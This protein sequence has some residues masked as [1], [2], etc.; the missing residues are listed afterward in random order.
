MAKS[1]FQHLPLP[2]IAKGTAKISGGGKTG[3]RTKA[4][5]K[6]RQAHCETISG[7]IKGVSEATAQR[8][9]QR[10]SDAPPLPPGIPLVLEIDTGLPLDK[11]RQYFNFEIVLEDEDGYVIV[12]TEDAELT[13]LQKMVDEFV[14]EVHGSATAASIYRVDD[15]SEQT[16]RLE[17]I[18][19]NT[20]FETWSTLESQPAWIVDVGVECT[21]TQEID[22]LPKRGVRDSDQDWAK[23]QH[24]WSEQRLAAYEQWDDLKEVRE[25]EV[26]PI[27]EAYNGEILQ[28][29]DE[30]TFDTARLPDSFT[31]R[32]RLSGVGL[33]DFVLNYAYIFEVVEPDDIEL[34]QRSGDAGDG[35]DEPA[36]TVLSPSAD[37]PTVCVIDSG[38]QESHRLIQPAIDSDNSYSYLPDDSSV[39]DAVSAGGHGT[40]VAGA[41]IFGERVPTDGDF[42]AEVWVQNARVLNADCG[43]PY[44]LLPAALLEAIVERYHNGPKLTRIFNQS[45]NAR[46]PCRLKHMSSWAAAIDILSFNYDILLIQ[47]AGNVPCQTLVSSNP[48]VEEHLNAGR[49]YPDFLTERS[50][51][52][53]NPAQ[54]FQAITVGSVAYGAFENEQ[55]ESLASRLGD[56]SA[57]SRSGLGIWGV[58]KPDVVEYGGDLL[59]SNSGDT[60]TPTVGREQYPE[61]VRSTLNGGPA[62]DRDQVGTS[63]A[64]PKVTRIA[65]A[66]QQLLPDEPS[67]LYRALIIHSARWPEWVC[68]AGDTY[69]R[70]LAMRMF[71]FGIPDVDRATSSGTYRSTLISK[72][73]QT[74]CPN[75]AKVFQIPV[76]QELRQQ[77]ENF[78]IQIQV[79][80]S[81]AAQPRRTRRGRRRYLSTWLEWKT[82]NLR[83]SLSSFR[84][85]VFKDDDSSPALS[86]G[87]SIPW[88]IKDQKHYGIEGVSRS[89]GTVQ[90]DWAVVKSNELPENFC[91]AVIGHKGWSQDPETEAKFALAVSFESVTQELEIHEQLEVAVD[92]L[93]L[94]LETEV[95]V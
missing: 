1:K 9:S 46:T 65:A 27:A 7:Q 77:G 45:I 58:T 63:F 80:L 31:V 33:R 69:D 92:E 90:K 41:V 81:Y 61:L 6:N 17:R 85:R 82:S 72:G 3:D 91:V 84:H 12:A 38:I 22:K 28:I 78:D 83:E 70:L 35:G 30:S 52:I 79:T 15:D 88:V 44:G 37:A 55:W 43:M 34:P 53:S 64:A 20:I 5:K 73:I 60:G 86:T 14:E 11:L 50:F 62:C 36:T 21:G 54:S 42:Q 13:K 68:E 24:D 66:L 29:V 51:R 76:P 2:F 89:T 19:S 4:H 16:T 57:F 94:E 71:G 32:L 18:L 39:A 10:P 74:I 59:I 75:E 67:L 25:E 56:A 93:V 8:L 23:K 48:G 49:A 95:E 26:R 47:S 87:T 40:R